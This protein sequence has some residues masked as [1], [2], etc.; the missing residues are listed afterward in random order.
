MIKATSGTIEPDDLLP[1]N[2]KCI[3]HFL[4]LENINLTREYL[5]SA[6]TAGAT[7]AANIYII[8][9]KDK[10][11]LGHLNITEIFYFQRL[12]IAISVKVSK[13]GTLQ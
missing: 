1:N 7:G 10:K 2:D 9:L 4:G 13:S 11:G 12:L 3:I 8:N 5:K 6:W